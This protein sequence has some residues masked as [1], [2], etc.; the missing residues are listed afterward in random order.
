MIV[1]IFAIDPSITRVQGLSFATAIPRSHASK[2]FTTTLSRMTSFPPRIEESSHSV[3]SSLKDVLKCWK[4]EK[5][6]PGGIEHQG[7]DSCKGAPLTETTG[8]IEHQ[9]EDSRKG[10]PLTEHIE[11]GD[12][13]HYSQRP[14][15]KSP[16]MDTHNDRPAVLITNDDGIHAPGLRALVE[17]LVNLDC[18]HVYVCAPD[19][20][21]SG[22]GHS[23]TLRKTV[24][25]T[26]VDIKGTLAY[27][28]S[29]SPA[30]CVSLG[31]SGVLFP[32]KKPSLVLSGINKGF[33]C[34]YH[35]HYSGTVAGAREALIC[36]VSA[37][38]LSLNWKR[39]ES[40]DADFKVAASLCLPLIKAALGDANKEFVSKGFYLSI[41]I[42]THPSNH[43]GFKVT[44]QGASRLANKWRLVSPNNRF[45]GSSLGKENAIGVRLAQLSIAASAV[46]AARQIN[47]PLKNMEIESI[48]GPENESG[49]PSSQNRLYCMNDVLETEVWNMDSEYDFGALN[50]GYIAVTP[51]GLMAH[52]D[53]EISDWTAEW[54]STAVE[55][56]ATSAL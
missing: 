23:V 38:A 37:I 31:L 41:E 35:T 56:I 6:R 15:E 24:E 51:L 17:A 32:S 3:V 13:L 18:C 7:E 49:L 33:N 46:G 26:P 1:S 45:S 40:G 34:G 29:G 22:A 47:S 20:D 50:E 5:D 52:R 16:K 42:P 55:F 10:A 30:D 53:L 27:E 48:A 14:E 9:V 19:C 12:H 21:K 39:E 4:M 54:I 11:A 43:K 2:A 44:R 28:V 36:G 8:D 25:V